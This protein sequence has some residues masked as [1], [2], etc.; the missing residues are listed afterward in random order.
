MSERIKIIPEPP[1]DHIS[2]QIIRALKKSV[3]GTLRPLL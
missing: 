1:G 2:S 3:E